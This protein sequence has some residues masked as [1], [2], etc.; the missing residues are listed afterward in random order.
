MVK[1]KRLIISSLALVSMVFVGSTLAANGA[2]IASSPKFNPQQVKSIQK[3]IHNYLIKNPEVLLQA[4]VALRKKMK[5]KQQSDAMQA[6]Q[7]NKQT[8]FNDANSPTAGNPNGNIMMVE[9]FDY[10]CPHCKTMNATV[11]NLIKKNSHIK[12]LILLNKMPL[13]WF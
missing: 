9:F 12:L 2:P 11:Q 10:Q 4:S 8:L 3:I 7:A 1:I 5:E 13:F 6:I